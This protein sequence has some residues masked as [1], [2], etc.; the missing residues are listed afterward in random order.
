MEEIDA[1]FGK[2]VAGHIQ[3]EGLEKVA[4]THYDAKAEGH[5]EPATEVLAEDAKA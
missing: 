5:Q 2:A 4:A 3:D 1:L